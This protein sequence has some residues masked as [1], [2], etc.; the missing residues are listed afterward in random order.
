MKP[1]DTEGRFV[2][3]LRD[4]S[5]R[6]RAAREI[7]KQM[8]RMM[9]LHHIDTTITASSDV[10]VTLNV[11]LDEVTSVLNADAAVLLLNSHTQTLEYV[12]GRGFK[13]E[14]LIHTRLR[15]GQGYAGR[16]ALERHVIAVSNLQESPGSLSE[17]PLLADE[18]FIGYYAVPLIAKGQVK[19]VLEVFQRSAAEVETEWLNFLEMLAGQAAIAIDNATLFDELQRSNIELILAYDTTLEG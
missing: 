8:R 4:I 14:A 15:I 1:L 5:E 11:I 13:T 3:T 9:A 7:E 17:S 6:K 2:A 12:A 10:R 19:G 16:A 18:S